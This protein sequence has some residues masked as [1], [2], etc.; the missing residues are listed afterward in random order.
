MLT[1]GHKS[2]DKVAEC[3]QVELE[4]GLPS[5]RH[6][7]ADGLRR[8][9]RT[10]KIVFGTTLAVF[11]VAFAGVIIWGL[12]NN[13]ELQSDLDKA[14]MNLGH[15]RAAELSIKI[16]NGALATQLQNLQAAVSDFQGSA[17][18]SS[19][20]TTLGSAASN[21]SCDTSCVVDEVRLDEYEQW[22]D[23][24]GYWLGE[25][26]FMGEDGEALYD[27]AYWNYPYDHYKGFIV[28]SVSGGSYSQRNVFLYPPQTAVR[29]AED[30]RTMFPGDLCGVNGALK[31]FE[32]DQ[33]TTVCDSRRPG[34]IAGP[35]QGKDSTTELVGKGNALLYQVF[36]NIDGVK[37]LEHSQLTTI[38][39]LTDGSVHRTRTAQLF[40]PKSGGVSGAP[41]RASFYRERKVSESEFFAALDAQIA[42]YNITD[43]AV[44]RICFGET[45]GDA[46]AN[47]KRFLE[48]GR[49]WP[50]ESKYECPAQPISNTAM[51]QWTATGAGKYP[52]TFGRNTTEGERVTDADIQAA[53]G[54][55]AG[56]TAEALIKYGWWK[57]ASLIWLAAGAGKY[58]QTFGRNTTTNEF[59]TDSDVQAAL[60]VGAGLSVDALIQ[61]GWWGLRGPL[62][63]TEAGAGRYPSTFG[64][65]T[66]AGELVQ[67]T[68]IQAAAGVGAGLSV[69]ALVGYG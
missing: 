23:E 45:G 5:Q 30:D 4:T 53:L 8:A 36:D 24:D 25:Y 37:T 55:G 48:G 49:S 52:D 42:A 59:V 51:M 43:A 57:E 2:F 27:A 31:K 63:W 9:N 60:G 6:G 68:D 22:K 54:V 12:R 32:A 17:S 7:E 34:A 64:R 21:S 65:E 1:N 15:A 40:K 35:Y 26:T 61:Y 62:R 67:D 18:N 29:C 10:L 11:L 47:L 58:P 46:L 38:T 28:G 69:P 16:K 33:T 14:R 66:V 50:R 56:L 39:T 44:T 13:Q 20:P 3:E 19:A 41:Y